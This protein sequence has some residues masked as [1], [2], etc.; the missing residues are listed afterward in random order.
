V[1]R[2]V[3]IVGDATGKGS[4]LCIRVQSRHLFFFEKRTAVRVEEMRQRAVRARLGNPSERG[5]LQIP[6]SAFVWTRLRRISHSPT[7]PQLSLFNFP[8]PPPPHSRFPTLVR[9][10]VTEHRASPNGGMEPASIMGIGFKST[11]LQW[12]RETKTFIIRERARLFVSPASARIALAIAR[13][14]K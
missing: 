4:S 9:Q 1:F 5:A 3:S 11:T 8:V 12:C 7:C 2:R 6:R 13:L 10:G 14:R